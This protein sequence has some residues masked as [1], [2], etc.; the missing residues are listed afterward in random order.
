MNSAEWLRR[1]MKQK[2]AS[3]EKE[4]WKRKSAKIQESLFQTAE[5][6][7]AERVFLYL[8]Y[9]K[10]A[11]TYAILSDA[12]NQNKHVAVP[13]VVGKGHMEFYE[14]RGLCDVRPGAYGISEPFDERMLIIPS[15]KEKA[16]CIV[17]GLVFDETCNRIGYGGGFYDR[18][19][20]RYPFLKKIALAYDFSVLQSIPSSEYDVKMD[21]ILTETR[22]YCKK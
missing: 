3:L 8:S 18:Y 15:V 16:I 21:M 1:E 12:G 5:Y 19:L 14:I 2:R 6:Q 7:T 20:A 11:D 9:A 22:M 4:E 13:K 17:P 10:E